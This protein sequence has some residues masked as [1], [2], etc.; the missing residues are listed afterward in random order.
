MNYLIVSDIHGS[1]ESCEFILKE[2]E[3]G[4]YDKILCL[5]DVLYHGPRNDLPNNYNPKEGIR[6]LNQYKD[7]ILCVKGNC[8]AEVDQMVLDFKIHDFLDLKLNDLDIHLEHGHHLDLYKG[9]PNIIMSGHTHIPVLKKENGI[10]Y[11]NPGSIT[12]PKGGFKRSYAI[13]NN[14]KIE[15]KSL[16]N[17]IMF[18][19]KL[20]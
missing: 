12:I 11:L 14:D 7:S 17:E 4:I 15:I 19:I 6:L 16:D 20:N 10:I 5:G 2:F 13:L 1:S 8:E 18:S 3:K 9:C